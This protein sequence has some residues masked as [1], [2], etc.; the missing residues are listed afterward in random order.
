MNFFQTKFWS[1]EFPLWNSLFETLKCKYLKKAKRFFIKSITIR[2]SV[3]NCPR[4]D[5]L[6]FFAYWNVKWVTML[7]LL[8]VKVWDRWLQEWGQFAQIAPI[9]REIAREFLPSAFWQVTGGLVAQIPFGSESSKEH[10][11]NHR[12]QTLK[13][14]VKLRLYKNKKFESYFQTTTFFALGQLFIASSNFTSVRV[15]LLQFGRN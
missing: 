12:S 11:H 7:W 6:V 14:E 1:F 13:E 9:A 5:P 8:V 10:F 15:K 2:K 4:T 3:K